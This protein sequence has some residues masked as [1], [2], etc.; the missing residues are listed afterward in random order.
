MRKDLKSYVMHEKL[1]FKEELERMVTAKEDVVN[2]L[3]YEILATENRAE[4]LKERM[5]EAERSLDTITERMNDFLE[6]HCKDEN[7]SELL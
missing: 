7:V 6:S 3:K 2:K 4:Q 1:T 5:N